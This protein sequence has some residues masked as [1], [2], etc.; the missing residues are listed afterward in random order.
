ML[1]VRVGRVTMPRQHIY[2]RWILQ[3]LLIVVTLLIFVTVFIQKY[4]QPFK[5]DWQRALSGQMSRQNQA[6][7]KR[8]GPC[9]NKECPSDQISFYMHSGVANVVPGKICLY[10][11]LILGSTLN[12]AGVG[13][14]IVIVNGKTGEVTK[15]G[16]FDMYGG[17]VKPLI[18]FLNSIKDGSIV[19][20]ASFDEPATKLDNEAK[21]LIAELGSK[22]I[23]SLGFRDNWLFVGAK[24]ASKKDL[25]E[26]HTKNDGE[27]NAYD[28]W[29]E[30]IT[31][32]GCIPKYL[33]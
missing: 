7:V 13:I 16:H 17:E 9:E 4:S 18:T 12:N 1:T 10:N 25:F 31:L 15:T 21:K 11:T 32:T 22:Y 3:C 30:F 5:A 27:K 20:M 14:N 26:K 2:T 28:G 19:L 24:G 8:S 33:G 23:N 29:P 6:L